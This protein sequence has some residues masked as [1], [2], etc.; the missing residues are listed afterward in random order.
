MQRPEH[1]LSEREM[2]GSLP[3]GEFRASLDDR[4]GERRVLTESALAGLRRG[5]LGVEAEVDLPADP[6]AQL[7]QAAAV[8]GGSNRLMQGVIAHQ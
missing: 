1:L 7:D 3:R 5:R 2:A 4:L 8:R 6:G